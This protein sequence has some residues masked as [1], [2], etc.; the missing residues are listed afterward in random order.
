MQSNSPLNEE[1]KGEQRRKFISMTI[2][3]NVVYDGTIKIILQFM[4][5]VNYST[6][7]TKYIKVQYNTIQFMPLYYVNIL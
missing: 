2:Q 7:L 5:L 6:T 1:E 3:Y 4:A